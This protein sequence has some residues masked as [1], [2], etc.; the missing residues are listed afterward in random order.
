[1]VR[2]L[3]PEQ[4]DQVSM[5]IHSIATAMGV[6][7]GEAKRACLAAVASLTAPEDDREECTHES[8]R[9]TTKCNVMACEN[10]WG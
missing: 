10:Y 1:M 3:T 2:Q 6:S 9:G 4:H 8:V 5:A 7:Y